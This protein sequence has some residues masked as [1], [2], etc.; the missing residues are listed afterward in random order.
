MLKAWFVNNSN[1]CTIPFASTT[2]I[3]VVHGKH[4]CV[5]GTANF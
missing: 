3:G 2:E 1:L 4:I 5:V